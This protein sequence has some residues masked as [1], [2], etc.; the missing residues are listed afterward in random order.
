MDEIAH[1][2]LQGEPSSQGATA[3]EGATQAAEDG[4]Q[5][6]AESSRATTSTATPASASAISKPTKG[7]EA[8]AEP[9]GVE[10]V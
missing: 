8:E 1:G 10:D 9:A 3:A 7:R 5:A 2:Y 4:T 6:A